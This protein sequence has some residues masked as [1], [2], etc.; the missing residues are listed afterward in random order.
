[1]SR[2][3]LPGAAATAASKTS[4][5]APLRV[6]PVV[7]KRDI[8]SFVRLPARIYADDEQWIAPLEIEQKHILSKTNPF[9]EHGRAQFWVAYRGDQPVGRIS[10]QIDDLHIERYQDATGH[11][12][13][14]EAVDEPEVFEALLRTAEDWLRDQGMKHAVGP[15]NLSINGD[16]GV[17]VEGLEHPPM[18]LTGHARPYYDRRITEQGY[19]KARNVVALMLDITGEPPAVMTRSIRRGRS[20]GRVRFRPVNYD[21][22]AED[23]A[24]IGDIFN[25]AWSDNWSFVPWTKAELSELAQAL[26]HFVPAGFVQIG[27]ADDEPAAMIVIVPNLNE[28]TADLRGRVFP[29]GWL[30]LLWRIKR[31]GVHSARVA[32]MGV[33]KKQQGTPLSMN[34]VFG[35]FDAVEK[36]LRGSGIEKLELSW[37]LEDNIPM[38]HIEERMGGVPYKKYRIYERS[39][40]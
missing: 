24:I 25:D 8:G 18:F 7:T 6:E 31:T 35:L 14:F 29:F 33:R 12:G 40:A 23:M 21:K 17:L 28:L 20:S 32:M 2:K 36:P 38:L 19:E 13:L 39:L 37:M 15:F 27:Y 26:R 16:I 5:Q 4:G 10:A 30:R 22:L 3:P 9:F 11:F 1:M 34:L